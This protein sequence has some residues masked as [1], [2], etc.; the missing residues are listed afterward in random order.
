MLIT[1]EWAAASDKS[2]PHHHHHFIR[3]SLMMI[4]YSRVAFYL[5]S[6]EGT[7]MADKLIIYKASWCHFCAEQ[8][9]KAQEI[10]NKLGMQVETID[11]EACPVTHKSD[12]DRIDFVPTMK[13]NG[14]DVTLESLEQRLSKR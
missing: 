13:L 7:I 11:I 5:S 3:S 2:F 4:Y 8:V 1:G 12:C 10:A 9:P 14:L 6:G